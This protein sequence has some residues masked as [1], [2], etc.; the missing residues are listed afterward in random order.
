VQKNFRRDRIRIARR[1]AIT[2]RM[3]ARRS[4]VRA[5]DCDMPRSS[6]KVPIPRALLVSR[7][8]RGAAARKRERC[9][10][11]TRSRRDDRGAA[12][13]ERVV[14]IHTSST[15]FGFFRLLRY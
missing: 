4:R 8:I 12:A 13:R 3:R 11:R 10:A 5:C 2:P 15:R 1:G 14:T 7:K 9:S 6:Q